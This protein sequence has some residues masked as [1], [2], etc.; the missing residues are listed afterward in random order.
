MAAKLNKNYIISVNFTSLKVIQIN[1][2]F[3]RLFVF[4]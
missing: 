3:I 2:S 1:K 4:I